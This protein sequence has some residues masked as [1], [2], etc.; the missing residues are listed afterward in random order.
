MDLSQL[1]KIM[2]KEKAKVIIVENGEPILIVSPF[3]NDQQSLPL[4][5]SQN[6]TIVKEEKSLFPR[7]ALDK[8][9]EK[10]QDMVEQEAKIIQNTDLLTEEEMPSNDLTVEDL[11]F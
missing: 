4:Q 5:S 11:P 9:T 10:A 1:K 2:D 7:N 3:E 6:F 8:K